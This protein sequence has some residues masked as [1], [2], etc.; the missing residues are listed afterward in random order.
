MSTHRHRRRAVARVQLIAAA[1]GPL[2]IVGVVSGFMWLSSPAG[3]LVST[4]CV[5]AKGVTISCKLPGA[6]PVP[7][8]KKTA[9]P[10]APPTT[11]STK[12]VAPTITSK[13]PAVAASPTAPVT[14][15][16]AAPVRTSASK[17]AHG[18]QPAGAVASRSATLSKSGPAPTTSNTTPTMIAAANAARIG[19]TTRATGTG[20]DSVG[21]L[22]IAALNRSQRSSNGGLATP[23]L[24]ALGALAWLAGVL[25]V[26]LVL[27]PRRRR[28]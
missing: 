10:K 24:L 20:D 21:P 16:P 5:N 6:K 7:T 15:A 12:P 18:N 28:S 4:H 26:G 1:A 3:A 11:A 8:K 23:E 22:E 13:P 25:V 27:A 2:L 14:S 17:H 9:T 19:P